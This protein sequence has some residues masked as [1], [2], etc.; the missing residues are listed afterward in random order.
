[1]D[2]LYGLGGGING[3]RLW[4]ALDLGLGLVLV[5]ASVAQCGCEDV[6]VSLE[7]SSSSAVLLS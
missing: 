4:R 2:W 3:V 7:Q 6:C 5:L 1:M